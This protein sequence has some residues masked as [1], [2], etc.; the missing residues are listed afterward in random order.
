MDPI[1][2][3][4][5]HF[6][7]Q[8]KYHQ[9]LSLS[10]MDFSECLSFLSQKKDLKMIFSTKIEFL[11]TKKINYLLIENDGSGDQTKIFG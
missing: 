3:N 2:I 5:N 4:F 7:G 9:R 11:A 1:D 8:N 6:G 10:I